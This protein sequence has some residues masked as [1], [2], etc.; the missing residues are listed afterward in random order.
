MQALRGPSAD[1]KLSFLDGIAVN[2]WACEI[3]E[4]SSLGNIPYSFKV[5]MVFILSHSLRWADEL[6][7]PGFATHIS[8]SPTSPASQSITM[9]RK[10]TLL[11]LLDKR[12]RD[13]RQCTVTKHQ[14]P[15]HVKF[16][17]RNIISTRCSKVRFME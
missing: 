14:L 1:F 4:L 9:R 5:V 17:N 15:P 12:E 10:A 11:Y 16:A 6:I 8:L 7:L 3:S 13:E 2:S